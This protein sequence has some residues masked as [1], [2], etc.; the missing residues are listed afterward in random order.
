MKKRQ[1]QILKAIITHFTETAEPVGSNTILVSYKFDVSPATIRNDMVSLEKQGLIYQPH[2]SSGRIPTD[3]GYRLYVDS[4]A[5][6]QAVAEK[7]HNR[8]N[9]IREELKTQRI[10]QKVHEAVSILARATQNVSF[11][12]IGNFRTFYLGTANV[13]KQPE[14]TKDPTRTSQIFEVLE[15]NNNFISVLH[16]LDIVNKK[17]RIYIGEENILEQ[18]KSCSII[19]IKYKYEDQEGFLGILGPTRMDYPLNAITLNE[20]KTL[21]ETNQL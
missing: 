1:E 8:L 12:T 21:L 2:T 4:L 15:D 3:L 7:A 18:I 19:V 6:Y 5:D 14:F 20:V 16:S 17:P 13:L 10:K 11:A 9:I